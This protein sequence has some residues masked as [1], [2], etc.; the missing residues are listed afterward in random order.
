VIGRWVIYIVVVVIECEFVLI[1]NE[2]RLGIQR[3]NCSTV[4]IEIA[5]STFIEIS[6]PSHQA[7]KPRNRVFGLVPRWYNNRQSGEDVVNR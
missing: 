3:Y 6:R 1:F 7:L 4:G 2:E 5:R